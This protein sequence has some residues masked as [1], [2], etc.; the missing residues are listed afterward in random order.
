MDNMIGLISERGRAGQGRAGQGI[1]TETSR[2]E[3]GHVVE[4][5][6]AA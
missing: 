3:S 2:V 4:D 6:L 1:P 5:A